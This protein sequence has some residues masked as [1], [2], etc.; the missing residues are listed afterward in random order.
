MYF[1]ITLAFSWRGLDGL[2]ALEP[3]CPE[4]VPSLFLH[5]LLT[6]PSFFLFYFLPPPPHLLHQGPSHTGEERGHIFQYVGTHST[7]EKIYPAV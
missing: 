7:F 3:F 6:F 5:K 2:A 4:Q 1:K